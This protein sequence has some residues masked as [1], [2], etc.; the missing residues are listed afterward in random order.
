MVDRQPNARATSAWPSS[1]KRIDT[2]ATATQA[3]TSSTLRLAEPKIAKT[4]KKSARARTGKPRTENVSAA[5]PRGDCGAAGGGSGRD[6]VCT[7]AWRRD[8]ALRNA[9]ADLERDRDRDLEWRR[10]MRGLW[11]LMVRVLASLCEDP[12]S[13]EHA[14]EIQALAVRLKAMLWRLQRPGTQLA[15][16]ALLGDRIACPRAA[17][18]TVRAFRVGLEARDA[19]I[20]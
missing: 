11:A 5:L 12:V 18:L 8:V 6:T 14:D 13:A 15:L 16:F 3:A 9:D 1:W 10:L 20:R 2:N 7:V 19:R 17:V 4:M